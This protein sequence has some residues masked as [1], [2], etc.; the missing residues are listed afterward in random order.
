[1][2]YGSSLAVKIRAAHLSCSDS[3][4]RKVENVAIIF[5]NRLEEL[6]IAA[7]V[8]IHAF[9]AVPLGLQQIEI[10]NDTVQRCA[11]FMADRRKQN[12]DDRYLFRRSSIS[13]SDSSIL[14]R[15][16]HLPTRNVTFSLR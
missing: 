5:S 2:A 15:V 4:S 11:Q 16:P 13:C 7:T 3:L 14:T 9:L 6:F 12:M 10:A 8:M 1:M